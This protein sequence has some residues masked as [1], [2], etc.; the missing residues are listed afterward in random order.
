[1][2]VVIHPTAIVETG[3]ELDEDVR[4][5][6]FAYIGS[7]AQIGA[8]TVIH[9]HASIELTTIIGQDC[10]VFPYA[11]IGGLSQD[12][13]Y[14]GE[15]SGV[16]IGDRTV[17][18]EFTTIHI[19]TGE[20]KFT[21]LGNDNFILAYSHIAHDCSV[22]NHLIMSSH[23]ALAG[24]VQIGDHVNIGWSTGIHQFC[25]VGSYAMLGGVTKLV[26]DVPPY[27]LA[28]GNP[29]TVK[30]INKVGLQRAGFSKE[31]LLNARKAYK[32]LYRE[33]LLRK[34][35]IAKM[36]AEEYKD[37][38]IMQAVI[39]FLQQSKRGLA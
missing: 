1:M 28:D 2:S 26:Q 6:A 20:G 37:S 35:A 29:A 32:Y 22:G 27:M 7:K 38:K 5:G 39:D 17:L 25:K 3:A 21:T 36:K 14:K 34:D 4:V 24:H 23:A 33:G 12:L 16:K 15:D 9:H 11:L 31:E 10:E 30:T 18:R 13:K 8:R 19:A